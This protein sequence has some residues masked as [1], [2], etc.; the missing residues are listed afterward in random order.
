MPDRE[1]I[2]EL[3]DSYVVGGSYAYDLRDEIEECFAPELEKAAD[4]DKFINT[5]RLNPFH[6]YITCINCFFRLTCAK[7]KIE[8]KEVKD[9]Q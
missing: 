4:V 1:R 2:I 7:K 9:G 5:C 6:G 3:L 8:V